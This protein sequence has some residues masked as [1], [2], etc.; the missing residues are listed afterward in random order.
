MAEENSNKTKPPG[1]V[2]GTSPYQDDIGTSLINWGGKP[3]VSYIQFLLGENVFD[4]FGD[5]MLND[6]FE[7]A[8]VEISNLLREDV[9]L[10]HLS[11]TTRYYTSNQAIY[12]SASFMTLYSKRILKVVRQNTA[13]EDTTNNDQYY[14]DARKI[15]NLDNQAVNPNSIYYENDPFNPAWCV[16]SSG[17]L[18]VFPKDSSA[19]PTA[20]V[21][22]MTFPVFG[23][24]PEIDSHITHNLGEQGGLQ[25]FSLVDADRERE[26]FLGIPKDCRNAIYLSMC[27]NLIDGYLSNNVQEEED[28]ELVNLLKSQAEWLV[29]MKVK[30]MNM[31]SQ[32][33]GSGKPLETTN[34]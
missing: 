33:Y 13:D 34:E 9:L 14:Y 22:Y 16:N 20:K 32:K 27:I 7:R 28:I 6:S 3:P 23:L 30:D 5:K 10:E 2:L 12:G 24:G 26:I 31:I 18:D 11:E 29:T 15:Q 19:V 17:G 25:N 21:Y 8:F 1:S 4:L